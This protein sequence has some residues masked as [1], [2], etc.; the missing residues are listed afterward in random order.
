MHS[1]IK[2]LL[3]SAVVISALMVSVGA[4]ANSD[5]TAPLGFTPATPSTT[6]KAPRL[7]RLQAILCDGQS[8]CA[9]ILNGL[10]RK[11]GQHINGFVVSKI[12]D[13]HVEL[14]R[15]GKRWTLTVFNSQLVQ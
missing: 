12:D 1:A 15:D 10:S 5:P 7:P 3:R 2:R 13:S 8:Q 6:Q 4:F 14:Q 11:Q 9:A